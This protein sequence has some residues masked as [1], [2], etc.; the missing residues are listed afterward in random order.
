MKYAAL[1]AIWFAIHLEPTIAQDREP[2]TVYSYTKDGVRHYS[3]KPA[4]PGATNIRT[5]TYKFNPVGN[6]HE[7]RGP[8]SYE[9][10]DGYN[11][12][13]RR[14]ANPGY[15]NDPGTIEKGIWT[16]GPKSCSVGPE[17]GNLYIQAGTERCC[18]SAGF[19]GE[20]LVLS[21]L[22]Q[23]RFVGVCSDRVLVRSSQ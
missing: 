17:Q 14:A 18:Y 16:A 11:F 4:P 5:I 21:A 15:T 19:L 20:N 6:W 1:A 3:A 9:F 22:S 8:A 13:Y 10:A 12:E 23:P 7:K 2:G